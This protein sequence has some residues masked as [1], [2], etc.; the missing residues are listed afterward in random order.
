M[1]SNLKSEIMMLIVKFDTIYIVSKNE[2]RF[3][4]LPMDVFLPL[5]DVKRRKCRFF[6]LKIKP[7]KQSRLD[8]FILRF[9]ILMTNIHVFKKVAEDMPFL[10][11]NTEGPLFIVGFARRRHR[12]Y[13]R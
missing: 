8:G 10:C 3:V 12:F 13:R 9:K 2:K 1:M 4:L 7:S 11:K 6:S 5:S